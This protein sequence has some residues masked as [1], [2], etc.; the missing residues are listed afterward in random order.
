MAAP[1]QSTDAVFDTA[2]N[3]SP[4]AAAT[5]ASTSSAVIVIPSPSAPHLKRKAQMMHDDLEPLLNESVFR[6]L[7]VFAN[8]SITEKIKIVSLCRDQGGSSYF[9]LTTHAAFGHQISLLLAEGDFFDA[10][11][12]GNALAIAGRSVAQPGS[13]GTG[14]GHGINMLAAFQTLQIQWPS[15][16]SALAAPS[17]LS[18][19]LVDTPWTGA[20]M[21]LDLRAERATLWNCP[22]VLSAGV[23]QR[24]DLAA[25]RTA[26]TKAVARLA[27]PSSPTVTARNINTAYLQF[28]LPFWT[29]QIGRASCRERVCLYV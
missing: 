10:P 25:Y 29:E 28:F 15:I 5:L 11:A 20:R 27:D 3:P 13:E 24:D 17:E 23:Q 26:V 19:S 6:V 12:R 4:R 8:V 16:L 7:D 1:T 9:N 22:E 14:F 21:V 2:R 18:G